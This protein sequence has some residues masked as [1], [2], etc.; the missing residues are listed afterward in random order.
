MSVKSITSDH[1]TAVASHTV[2]SAHPAV[3]IYV[4]TVIIDHHVLFIAVVLSL[5]V[6]ILV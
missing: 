4:T 5:V 2:R 6:N 1:T 3:M